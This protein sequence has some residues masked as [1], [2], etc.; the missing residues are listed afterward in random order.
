MTKFSKISDALQAALAGF[1]TEQEILSDYMQDGEVE[2]LLDAAFAVMNRIP[3][4]GLREIPIYRYHF[5]AGDKF[6]DEI[7]PS[8]IQNNGL[9][10]KHAVHLANIQLDNYI[11]RINGSKAV[12]RGYDVVYDLDSDEI[13]LLYYIITSDDSITTVYRT[14]AETFENFCTPEFIIDLTSQ[15]ISKLKRSHISME[16][17]EK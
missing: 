1:C 16:R 17:E 15:I 12:S 8:E 10:C 5:Y 3:A 11:D 13:R 9:L 2:N 4:G 7:F 14:N 6:T